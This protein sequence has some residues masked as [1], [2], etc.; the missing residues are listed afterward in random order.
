MCEWA[1]SRRRIGG[2]ARLHLVNLVMAVSTQQCARPDQ[3]YS[4]IVVTAFAQGAPTASLSRQT[5][6]FLLMPMIDHTP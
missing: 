5:L 1:A 2:R 6:V 4:S 3:R